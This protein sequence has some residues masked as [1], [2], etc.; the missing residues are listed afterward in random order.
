MLCLGWFGVKNERSGVNF[1]MISILVSCLHEG[2]Y[3]LLLV[4]S[5]N[6]R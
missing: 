6:K 2:I 3:D 5:I 4:Q 1:K